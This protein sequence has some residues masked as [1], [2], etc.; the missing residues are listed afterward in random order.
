MGN[1]GNMGIMN[2]NANCLHTNRAYRAP[3]EDEKAIPR[4][5]HVSSIPMF[6]MFPTPPA[7]ARARAHTRNEQRGDTT[8]PT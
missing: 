1:M 5:D 8:C 7:R 3:R 2:N 6:P 4:G